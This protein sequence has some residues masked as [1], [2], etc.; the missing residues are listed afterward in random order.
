MLPVCIS[1]TVIAILAHTLPLD[2]LALLRK[3]C[4]RLTSFQPANNDAASCG[5]FMALTSDSD[6]RGTG[7]NGGVLRAEV[8]AR[9]HRAAPH[10]QGQQRHHGDLL[11]RNRRRQKK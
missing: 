6:F 1:E 7:N 9:P 5:R 2:G 8:E 3:G 10:L 11:R 4:N